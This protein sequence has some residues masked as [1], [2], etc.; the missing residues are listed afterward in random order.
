[1]GCGFSGMIVLAVLKRNY[2]DGVS[3]AVSGN[4]HGA[5]SDPVP[6]VRDPSSPI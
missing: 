1:M 3:L 6:S 5:F 4:A 2:I